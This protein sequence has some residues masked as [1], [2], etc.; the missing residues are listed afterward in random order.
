MSV[1]AG[2]QLNAAPRWAGPRTFEPLPLSATS[3]E[4]LRLRAATLAGHLREDPSVGLDAA[5]VAL[6][7]REPAPWRA[8]VDGADRSAALGALDALAAGRD[9]AAVAVGLARGAARTAFLFPGQGSQ[10]RQMA[11]DLL[12]ESPVY[13]GLIAACD[14]ALAPYVEWSLF[15]VLHADDGEWLDR[16]EVVQPALWAVMVG[17]GGLWL[18]HGVAPEVVV[19][20]SQGEVAAACISGALSLADGARIV[21]ARSYAVTAIAGRGAMLAVGTGVEHVR[22][23][24][25]A[26]GATASIAAVNGASAVVVSGVPEELDELRAIF[27]AAGLRSSRVAVDIAS[28]S[29]QVDEVRDALL[30]ALV[31]LQPR[32]ATIPLCSTVTASVVEPAALDAD[33]WFRNLRQT[34]LLEP[35][36][37]RL[38]DDGIDLLLEVSPRPVLTT[39][40]EETVERR[41]APARAPAVASTLRRGAGDRARFGV[42]LAQAWVEG[43]PV[44]W[45]AW[46][47]GSG[48]VPAQLP[49]FAFERRRAA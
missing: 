8:V 49:T 21:A 11:I 43:A 44:D 42:A 30:G 18:A 6:A 2:R 32:P 20:H 33:Y 22:G 4:A 24:L 47:A 3:P 38:I 48:V 34:V 45:A 37:S 28:H 15:D 14:A 17:L 29:A 5:A 25:E 13:A 10:W 27:K 35:V 16:V 23:V 12:D 1:Q 9:S 39:A 31:G 26:R 7:L 36:V 41:R 46:H 40:L 19:G